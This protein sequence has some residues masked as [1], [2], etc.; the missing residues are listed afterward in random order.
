MKNV[1]EKNVKPLT[2]KTPKGL[3]LIYNSILSAVR[4]CVFFFFFF[5]F[6]FIIICIR[7]LSFAPMCWTCLL[8]LSSFPPLVKIDFLSHFV[9]RFIYLFFFLY[10]IIHINV[11]VYIAMFIYIYIYI[12]VCVCKYKY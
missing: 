5:Y 8:T 2:R 12:Y 7:T 1:K 11:Y 3:I 9:F 4:F 6:L 10:Q